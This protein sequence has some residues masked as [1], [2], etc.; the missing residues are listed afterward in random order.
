VRNV[1]VALCAVIGLFFAG[2]LSAQPQ[3]PKAAKETS[4]FRFAIHSVKIVD[5]G[6]AV[7]IQLLVQ[8]IAKTRQYL[9]L[10]GPQKVSVDN[11]NIGELY[12]PTIAGISY[13][14]GGQSSDPTN[15]TLCRDGKAKNLDN[16]TYIEPN[17]MVT[18]ALTYRFR[19][20]PKAFSGISF[21]VLALARTA[22]GEIDLLSAEAASK[23]LSPV[24][25]V[26]VSF[27]LV[28]MSD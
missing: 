18:L 24:R 8:N 1:I 9:M 11:G 15:L 4:G 7:S 3:Q 20:E 14:R 13:C 21:S 5:G 28:S 17:E 23:A 2:G 6:R 19:G 10:Y 25:A 12:E 27:P 26:N 16:Y 22:S